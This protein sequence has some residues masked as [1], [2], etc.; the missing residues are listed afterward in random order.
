MGV[1]MERY[2]I[3]PTRAFGLLARLSEHSNVR[4]LELAGEIVGS[5]GGERPGPGPDAD[6][7]AGPT[8][9]RPGSPAD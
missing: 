8:G 5:P 2:A 6:P 1:L 9:E 3:T 7:G 4:L